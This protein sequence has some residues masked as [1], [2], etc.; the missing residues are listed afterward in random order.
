MNT[1]SK[2]RVLPVTII[3][4]TCMLMCYIIPVTVTDCYVVAYTNSTQTY[5]CSDGCTTV[6][7]LQPCMYQQKTTIKTFL[8]TFS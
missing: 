8:L 1:Q 3:M 5:H 6:N 7:V 4:F 2:M